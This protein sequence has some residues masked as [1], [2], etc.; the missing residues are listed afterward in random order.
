MNILVTGG[1][2]YIGSHTCVELLNSNHSVIIADNF[3]NSKPEV[4]AKIKQIT[5]K[6]LVFYEIDVTQKESVE[7][8]FLENHIDGIIH[9][10]G[11]K[12]VG[13]SVSNPTAYYYNNLVSTIV[14]SDLCI[15]Y[16]ISRFV[17]S[18]SATVYGDNCVPF[19]EDMKLLPTTNPYGET[20]VMSERMLTDL[21]VANPDIGVS[22]LSLVFLE[23]IMLRLMVQGLGIISML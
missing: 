1:C 17:F 11:F 22:L 14:L 7:A 15:Q 10:A 23:T 19:T 2:G 13:E 4:L 9:F 21:V 12:A 6:D 18:S 3:S 8:I 20:K 5:G 16:G